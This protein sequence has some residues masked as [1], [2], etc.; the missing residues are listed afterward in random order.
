MGSCGGLLG[1]AVGFQRAASDNLNLALPGERDSMILEPTRN[2]WLSQA[3]RI[4]KGTL[5]SVVF[6]SLDGRHTDSIGSL[7][8][9]VKPP[10]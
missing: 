2:C 1:F 6:N 9:I 7:I 3:E 10:P 5:R 4:G 8:E